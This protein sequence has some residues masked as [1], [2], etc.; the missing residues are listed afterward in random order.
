MHYGYNTMWVNIELVEVP[1]LFV[2]G[3]GVGAF[4]YK[5]NLSLQDAYVGIQ[6]AA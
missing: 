6:H 5:Q 4:T 3:P 2:V 1:T